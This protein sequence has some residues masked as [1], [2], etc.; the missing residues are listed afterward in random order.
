S[1]A[2]AQALL[3]DRFDSVIVDHQLP[4]GD[5]LDLVASVWATTPEA[6]IVVCSDGRADLRP[7]WVVHVPR[8]HVQTAVGA[9]GLGPPVAAAGPIL[10]TSPAAL[11]GHWNR[12]CRTAPLG[13]RLVVAQQLIDVFKGR[14]SPG[15]VVVPERVV[16]DVVE[17]VPETV[18]IEGALQDLNCLREVVTG[19]IDGRAPASAAVEVMAGT[20]RLIDAT[21]EALLARALERLRRE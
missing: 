13:A 15:R 8:S 5:G 10:D 4:D 1:L 6:H 2:E 17:A 21:A 9:L 3:D 16:T 18:P 14:A 12:R 11:V 20:N 7:G 19:H